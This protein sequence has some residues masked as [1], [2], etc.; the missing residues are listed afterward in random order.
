MFVYVYKLR[1]SQELGP[2]MGDYLLNY[3]YHVHLIFG[4]CFFSWKNK[5]P[6]NTGE[7]SRTI[8][9]P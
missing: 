6:E 5:S 1:D 3:K 8:F 7:R 2:G 4:L 9:D